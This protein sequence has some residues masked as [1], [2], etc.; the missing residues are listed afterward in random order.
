MKRLLP[1]TDWL[2]RYTL[3]KLQGDL[4]AG[5]AVGLM[6]IP[7]SLAHAVIAG[8]KPQYGLYSS[9]PAMF[10]Y[11]FLGTSK[12]VSIGT[13]VIT[14]LLAN[15]YSISNDVHPEIIAAL[16]FVV[17]IVMILVAVCRLGFV[18]RFL[19]FPVI[20]GFVSASSIIISVSQLRYFF[21]LSRSP[22]KVFLKIEHLFTNIKHTR[23]GDATIGII[24]FV[25]LLVL[26]KAAKHKWETGPD[27]T[28]LRRALIK[29]ARVI[30][31]GRNAFVATLAI[32]VSY[33]LHEH[34]LGHLFM[35][36]GNLPKGL[37]PFKM[38]LKS[39]EI[40]ANKTLTVEQLITGF[41]SGI[42]VLPLIIVLQSVAASKALGRLNK[43]K[44]DTFQEIFALGLGNVFG[45]FFN[46]I[47]MT[48]SFSRSAVNSSSGSRTPLAGV[49]TSL[50]VIM[51][52]EFL[53]PVIRFA[54]MASLSAIVIA[55]VISLFDYQL[56]I[57]LWRL[58]K[59]DLAIW[60]L[61]FFGCIYEIEIGI[62]I[63]VCL[64]LAVVMYREFNPRLDVQ[65][66]KESRKLV[67]KLQGGVWFPGIESIAGQISR[68]LDKEGSFIDAVVIDCENMLEVDYTVI[69]GLTEIMADCSLNNVELQ[70]INVTGEKMKRMFA[71]EKLVD[72][73]D[74]TV[75]EHPLETIES[76]PLMP[77]GSADFQSS[78]VPT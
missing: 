33:A 46:S 77:N 43:Y 60:V 49:L 52:I 37:P 27:T 12:D 8:L 71:G 1:I 18:V 4:V 22:R 24:S 53:G 25:L 28:K 45:S 54:P 23:P 14:A 47:P 63:G 78:G 16:T 58:N 65:L 11:L 57:K 56:A 6:I 19:S 42:G 30:G 62:L 2:P 40:S 74:G 72:A 70:V 64:S 76:G 10:I 44:I 67:I 17:G 48:A 34:G 26:Q 38:P 73:A 55:A 35:S 41:G 32:L 59:I 13:T 69:H 50:V 9:F 36:V 20:S 21:G 31:I 75:E 66:N 15:R 3:Q 39:I 5:I 61:T 7:Q 68:K 51:A 29:V